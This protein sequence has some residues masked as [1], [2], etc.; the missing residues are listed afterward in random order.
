MGVLGE[1][2]PGPK[3]RDEAGESGDGEKWRLGPIDL[4]R[5]TVVVHRAP[6]EEEPGPDG[7]VSE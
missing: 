1:L 3:I 7:P 6:A 2:F 5:G 4:E